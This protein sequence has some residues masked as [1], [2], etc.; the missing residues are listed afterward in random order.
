MWMNTVMPASMITR[1]IS[2]SDSP[3][4]RAMSRCFGGMRATMTEMKTTLSMPSTISIALKA[5]KLAQTSGS[6]RSSSMRE[7]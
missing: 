3:M 4:R 2:A 7:A 1:K 5:M 6:V